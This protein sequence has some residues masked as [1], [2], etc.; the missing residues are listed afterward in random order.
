MTLS[1]WTLVNLPRIALS[2]RLVPTQ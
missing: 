1:D 2:R